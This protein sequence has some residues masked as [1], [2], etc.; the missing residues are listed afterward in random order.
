MAVRQ[1]VSWVEDMMDVN[2]V[3]CIA[4]ERVHHVIPI[5]GFLVASRVAL[6]KI[7]RVHQRVIQVL[8]LQD[9]VLV[10]LAFHIAHVVPSPIANWDPVG[11][12]LPIVCTDSTLLA[13]CFAR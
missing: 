7:S 9:Q 3:T 6:Y 1:R 8:G 11:P 10:K 12:C 2:K 5:S 13:G 4:L